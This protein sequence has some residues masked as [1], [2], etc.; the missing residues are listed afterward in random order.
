MQLLIVSL[1]NPLQCVPA[2]KL[3]DIKWKSTQRGIMR[4]KGT[5]W[6][7]ERGQREEVEREGR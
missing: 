4:L 3:R 1:A 7:S 5:V 2:L 6:N